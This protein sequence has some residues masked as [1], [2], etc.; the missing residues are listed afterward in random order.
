MLGCSERRPDSDE[1]H[2][3]TALMNN[4]H[5]HRPLPWA[6]LTNN[7]HQQITAYIL[8]PSAPHPFPLVHGLSSQT[9]QRWDEGDAQPV[10]AWW[11]LSLG[12]WSLTESGRES[13]NEIHFWDTGQNVVIRVA[14]RTEF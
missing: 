1:K 8:P 13:S 9:G 7:Q 5:V 12:K 6:N 14:K 11:G 4:A 2:T 3:F 10:C